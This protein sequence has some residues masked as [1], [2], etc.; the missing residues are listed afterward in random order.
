MAITQKWHTSRGTP[1]GTERQAQI[2]ED[3]E[4]LA[5]DAHGSVPGVPFKLLADALALLM[6]QGKLA[7]MAQ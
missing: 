2:R 5:A 1:C 7:V 4:V 6:T 3:A